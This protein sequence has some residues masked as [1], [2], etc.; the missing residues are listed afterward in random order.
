MIKRQELATATLPIRRILTIDGGGIKGVF[1]AAFLAGLEDQ[2]GGPVADYFDLIAGTSTGGI[3]AIGLGLGLTSREIL[4][5]YCENANRIFPRGRGLPGRGVFRAK[6][7]N[8][9][10]R[11]VLTEVF[12][13]QVLGESS[14]RLVIPSLNLAAEK[15]HIYRTSHAASAFN[16]GRV[17]AVDVALAT[18]AAPSYFP[19]HLS[20]E[21]VP[22]IDGSL[23]ACNP[24][25]LAVIEALGTLGWAREKIRVLSLGC[26][27]SPL[28]IAWK[29]RTSFGSSYWGARLADVFFTAQSSS[30]LVTAQTLIGDEHV[31]RMNPHMSHQRFA[32]DAVEHLSE[33]RELGQTEASHAYPQLAPEFFRGKAAQFVSIIHPDTEPAA[34]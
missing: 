32:L 24:V 11:Q 22:F 26:T 1:P 33:L 23:W 12:G 14:T 27:S 19:I 16:D 28:N 29:K 13:E 9:A 34:A 5:L 2:L 17:R 20:P 25:G 18:V 31:F 30:A 21:G 6:Y 15:V 7:A 3:I 8:S 4:R 10:L